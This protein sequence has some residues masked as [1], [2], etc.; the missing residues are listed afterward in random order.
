M[1]LGPASEPAQEYKVHV[2]DIK[3]IPQD[4][5]GNMASVQGEIFPSGLLEITDI[6]TGQVYTIYADEN[7][8]IQGEVPL[9]GD[10]GYEN[11]IYTATGQPTAPLTLGA[12]P[13]PV[14]EALSI[15]EG[16]S[17]D[18]LVITGKNF[19]EDPKDNIVRINGHRAEVIDATPDKLTIIVP[20]DASAG[21]VTIKTA[22]KTSND[23]LYFDYISNGLPHGGFE[24]GDMRGFSTEGETHLVERLG[25]VAPS[26]GIYMM[27][28]SNIWN[29]L[30]GVSILTT[31]RFYVPDGKNTLSLD[32]F[33]LTTGCAGDRSSLVKISLSLPDGTKRVMAL[34]STDAE[35]YPAGS[36]TGYESGTLFYSF[37][38]DVSDLAGARIP[39]RLV[40]TLYGIRD[41][42][43]TPGDLVFDDDNPCAG[44][45]TPG[46][47]LL[48][49]HLRLHG[50]GT[51][52]VEILKDY[53]AIQGPAE[54]GDGIGSA[55]IIGETGAVRWVDSDGAESLEGVVIRATDFVSGRIF[56]T[57][58]LTDGGFSLGVETD[59]FVGSHFVIQGFNDE[60]G[61]GYGIKADI[62]GIL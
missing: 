7:G 42:P 38:M 34:F 4:G 30:D 59:L 56:T 51:K 58:V 61:L 54:I 45:K 43:Y 29:P 5:E 35:F 57:N 26:E 24:S 28:L 9:A 15:S 60:N 48:V 21:P 10:L 20:E 37:S 47:G 12:I 19:S 1:D 16:T 41:I 22:G 33:L 53:L 62:N 13:Y 25:K 31:D 8:E 49:D 6:E 40:L 50:M 23:D 46:S 11:I 32:L 3:I 18:I 14:A 2:F 27:Y 17:G 52:K 39:V 36:L 44:D 55:T